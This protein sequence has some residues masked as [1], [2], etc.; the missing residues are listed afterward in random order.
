M[1]Q[2][3]FAPSTVGPVDPQV[4]LRQKDRALKE[5]E[6]RVKLAVTQHQRMY[7]VQ[8]EHIIAEHDRTLQAT[9][10]AIEFEAATANQTL[11][12]GYQQQLR[13]M[14]SQVQSQRKQ[15][16]QQANVLELHAVQQKMIRE[17]AERESQWNTG[18]MLS[19]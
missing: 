5:L 2:A 9:R 17:H 12:A 10:A 3:S 16:E 15:I 18:Y 1:P 14:N 13:N 8:R 11:E 7:E 19:N 4:V 6:S